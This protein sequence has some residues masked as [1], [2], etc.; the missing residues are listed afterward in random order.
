MKVLAI[1]SAGNL[2]FLTPAFPEL[3]AVTVIALAA[4]WLAWPVLERVA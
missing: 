2:A 4:A 3:A 1:L